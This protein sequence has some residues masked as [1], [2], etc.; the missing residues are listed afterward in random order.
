[1]EEPKKSNR[2]PISVLSNV[3]KIYERCLYDQI[4]YF[5][6]MFSK[7]RCDFSKDINIQHILLA[8]MEKMKILRDSKPFC[9][10]ILTD[11]SIAFDCIRYDLLIAKLNGCGFDQEALKL[12]HSYLCDRSQKS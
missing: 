7:D 12:I 10:A 6:K 9:A 4:Y 11:L 5:D 3:S 8:I 1:M 2:R